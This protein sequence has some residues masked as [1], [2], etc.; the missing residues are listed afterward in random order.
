MKTQLAFIFKKP[1]HQVLALRGVSPTNGC[2]YSA[3]AQ[4][5]KRFFHFLVRYYHH[6]EMIYIFNFL[7]GTA[8]IGNGNDILQWEV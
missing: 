7:S 1:P 3:A 4:V 5:E 8:A 2:Q 6:L